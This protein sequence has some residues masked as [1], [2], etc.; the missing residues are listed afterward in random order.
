MN[1]HILFG[2][3]HTF[4][5]YL[6]RN[7]IRLAAFESYHIYIN[8]C[9]YT[10]DYITAASGVQCNRFVGVNLRIPALMF[11]VGYEPCVVVDVD[12]R[13]GASFRRH[14]GFIPQFQ[15]DGSGHIISVNME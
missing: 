9:I 8:I 3:A 6:V 5:G 14:I 4:F 7:R 13:I 10:Q 11:L 1:P 12:C 2:G 15:C